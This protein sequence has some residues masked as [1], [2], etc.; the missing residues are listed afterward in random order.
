MKPG[1][2]HSS[3]LC[4]IQNWTLFI[5]TALLNPVIDYSHREM[6]MAHKVI[7]VF[8]ARSDAIKLAHMAQH[9]RHRLDISLSICFTRRHNERLEQINLSVYEDPHRKPP[10]LL[11]DLSHQ[12]LQQFYAFYE[13]LWPYLAL[14]Q[15]D[16]TI[17]LMAALTAFNRHIAIWQVEAGLSTFDLKAQ[18]PEEDDRHLT[19]VLAHLNLPP[20][21]V[22][23][24][25]LLHEG[26]PAHKIYFTVNTVIDELLWVRHYLRSNQW[27][28]AAESPLTA[29]RDDKVVDVITAHYC[30]NPG[31]YFWHI[32]KV[33]AELS[34]HH[35]H[36]LWLPFQDFQ[37][38]A[39]LMDRVYL[40]LSD[41]GGLQEKVTALHKSFLVLYDFTGRSF[42]LKS[43]TVKLEGND[44]R[45]I[46]GISRELLDE[47]SP[48]LH[49][50]H[51]ISHL[52]RRYRE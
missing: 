19:A 11:K 23:P 47:S 30:E 34:N 37:C 28:L 51:V 46:V 3:E 39:W 50:K 36:V 4:S 42:A 44:T 40:F 13:E 18:W 31:E 38:F 6:P 22:S 48:D 12:I 45:H 41:S 16:T 52:C 21:P 29:M 17:C 49:I 26:V 9:L 1:T 15:I 5:S 32:Y 24:D 20:Q 27:H 2:I 7:L 10:A 8:S 14:I 43:G 33:L 35:P 25:S